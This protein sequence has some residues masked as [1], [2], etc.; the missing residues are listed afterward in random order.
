VLAVQVINH[1]FL[2]LK[3]IQAANQHLPLTQQT[4]KVVEAEA[5]HKQV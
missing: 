2:H 5:L 3:E 1:Q 4:T